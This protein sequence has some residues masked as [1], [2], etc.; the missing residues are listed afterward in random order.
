MI[1]HLIIVMLLCVTGG[2]LQAEAY[3]C[4]K[5]KSIPLLILSNLLTMIVG[6]LIFKGFV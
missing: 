5:V 6:M 2:M 3:D 4:A 1:T